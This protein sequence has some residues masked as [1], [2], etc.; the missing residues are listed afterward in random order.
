MINSLSVSGTEVAGK[1]AFVQEAISAVEVLGNVYVPRNMATAQSD[2]QNLTKYYARPRL[3]KTGYLPASVRRRVEEMTFTPSD[4][5]ESHSAAGMS[6]L[7]GVFGL[8]F[9]LVFTLQVATN[10][11]HQG[12]LAL[13]WQ[14]GDGIGSG[15]YDRG[16]SAF[17]ATNIPHVRCDLSTE[18]MVQLSV[19]F[20]HYTDF[21]LKH[22]KD[23]YGKLS[24]STIL[25]VGVAEGSAPPTYKLYLHLEDLALVGVSPHSI[26]FVDIDAPDIELQSGSFEKETEEAAHPYSS[27][28]AAAAK[29]LR[30]LTSG[31]PSL[32]SLAG[33]VA[34]HT[35]KLAGALRAFGFSKPI[36]REP[37]NRV[38]NIGGVLE[39]NVDVPSQAIMMAPMSNNHLAVDDTFTCSEADEMSFSYILGQYS[40]ICV[41]SLSTV[42]NHAQLLYATNISPSWFWARD[43]GPAPYMNRPVP[44]QHKEGTSGIIPSHA[45]FM[46]SGFRYWRGGFRFRFTFSK[47]KMHGGR[48]MIAYV[49]HISV[50]NHAHGSPN[51]RAV[52]LA[53]P[54]VNAVGL[55]PTG[56]TAVFDLRDG[57][58]FEFDVPYTGLSPFTRF[59][60]SVGTLSMY[61]VDPLQAPSVVCPTVDFLVEVSCSKDF[62]LACVAG[63]QYPVNRDATIQL[64]SGVFDTYDADAS[65]YTMGESLASVKQLIMI[66]K[67]TKLSYGP[68]EHDIDIMPWYYHPPQ[69]E[70]IPPSSAP[71]ES[72]SFGGNFAAAFCFA[73]GS[74]DV[75]VYHAQ[76]SNVVSVGAFMR[77]IT[78][79]VDKSSVANKPYVLSHDGSLH[80]RCPSYQTVS[81]VPAHI[82]NGLTWSPQFPGGQPSEERLINV[83]APHY[84]TPTVLPRLRVSL[85]TSSGLSTVVLKRAAGDDALLGHYMGPP[86]VTLYPGE[87]SDFPS[88]VETPV[89]PASDVVLESGSFGVGVNGDTPTV[90]PTGPAGPP[91]PIGP[92]G[93]AGPPG[94]E[95]P[96]GPSGAVRLKYHQESII[97][98]AS[99]SGEISWVEGIKESVFLPV[100]PNNVLPVVSFVTTAGSYAFLPAFC[101]K[102][103]RLPN[104]AADILVQGTAPSKT[105][106]GPCTVHVRLYYFE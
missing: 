13:S 56:H 83:P 25:P 54:E 20:L 6:R 43:K 53:L 67:Q 33:P 87:D 15:T 30:L 85:N 82:F 106:V 21:V 37:P 22:G 42:N 60:D 44:Y 11:F 2:L 28:L 94:P 50:G 47:S 72:Y 91:G 92:Q 80:M 3:L 89:Q 98:Y 1:T 5:L 49:P 14:Y 97:A 10:P 34:W 27:G 55:Q 29:S 19:P 38:Y 63:P 86:P 23:W 59:F 7:S 64:E 40:Q 95:G 88:F 16:A 35:D 48:V 103:T 84:Y 75:H 39:H 78:D 36:V 32:K 70:S 66:P 99:V 71:P 74:T 24:L 51:A 102:V 12:L 69:P 46:A 79:T 4:I 61:V 41:G 57:N 45:F 76:D 77:N 18:T 31:V 81:R 90:G 93:I 101:V 96:Q 52:V 17:T 62:E 65:K 100:D 104:G 58:V 9:R 26:S 68:T 73:R 105:G 8:R